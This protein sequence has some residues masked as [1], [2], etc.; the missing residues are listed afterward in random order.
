MRYA[1]FFSGELSLA[2]EQRSLFDGLDTLTEPPLPGRWPF[3][4]GGDALRDVN[5]GWEV[6]EAFPAAGPVTDGIAAVL[7][8]VGRRG[9]RAGVA[10]R[11]IRCRAVGSRPPA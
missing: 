6:A 8:G 1:R 4:R 7:S 2:G 3:V 5:A 10:G 9:E 11:R